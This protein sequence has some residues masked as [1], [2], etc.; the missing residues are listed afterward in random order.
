MTSFRNAGVTNFNIIVSLF[1]LS[2]FA[3]CFDASTASLLSPFSW[4]IIDNNL[5]IRLIGGVIQFLYSN[6]FSI[7]SWG[8]HRAFAVLRLIGLS[9]SENKVKR[10][11]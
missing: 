4:D 10:L 8:Q 6:D 1:R 3:R 5:E 9:S 11:Q 2:L 7:S